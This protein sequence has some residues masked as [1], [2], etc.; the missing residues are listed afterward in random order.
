MNWLIETTVYLSITAIILLAF[1]KLF[2]NKLSA[3]VQFVIWGLLL[4]RFLIPYLPESKM[5]VYNNIPSYTS[6][7]VQPGN[8]TVYNTKDNIENIMPQTEIA[9]NNSN[10]LNAENIMM[11]IWAIGAVSLF[12]YFV[13][14]YISF[15]FSLKKYK[16]I[17]DEETLDILSECKNITGIKRNIKILSGG[18]TPLLKGIINPAIILPE[19]YTISEKKDVFLHELCHLK[20]FDIPFT[21]LAVIFVCFNWFNPIIWYSFFVFRRDIEV[22]CDERTLKYSLEKKGY[23]TLLLKTA[24]RKNKFLLGTTA[25]QNGEKEVQRRICHIAYFKKPTFIWCAVILAVAAIICAVCLTNRV[26]NKTYDTT[27]VV[28]NDTNLYLDENLNVPAFNVNQN[29]IVS[30]IKS[31]SDESYYVQLPV[32]EI[33]PVC[34]YIKADDISFKSKDF[35][36]ANYAVIENAVVY[37]SENNED[38]YSQSE[39]GIINIQDYGKDF[40]KCSLIGGVDDKYVKKSDIDYEISSG[41]SLYALTSQYLSDEFFRVYSPYYE[42]LNLYISNWEQDSN[43]ATFFYTMTHK[44]FDKDPDTVEYIKEAKENGSTYYEQLKKEYL[45]PKESNYEFKVIYENDKLELYTNIDPK[46]F[47]WVPTTIDDFILN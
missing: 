30:I 37:N 32:M 21:W 28:T 41:D 42:I 47:E 45:E 13:L 12:L 14:T 20:H 36:N 24:L 16:N 18:D 19:G 11:T 39:S 46:G 43:S 25:F 9:E 31:N 10:K 23:A 1:K 7:S 29:D 15:L 6:I 35:T 17:T 8:N 2:K 27:A 44:N 4:I 38:I 22:Y 5:S 34:G 40:V 26:Q 33:P 3:R